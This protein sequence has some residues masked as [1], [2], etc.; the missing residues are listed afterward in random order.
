MS[1]WMHVRKASLWAG[2][3]YGILEEIHVQ[4]AFHWHLYILCSSS[5]E[6]EHI[7][8]GLHRCRVW[9]FGPNS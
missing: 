2:L 8:T 3:M 1:W 7:L 9:L 4:R 6:S 5:S